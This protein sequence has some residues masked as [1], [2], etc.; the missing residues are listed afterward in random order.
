MSEAGEEEFNLE[1]YFSLKPF[2]AG[3][4]FFMFLTL[5]LLL[6]CW[7]NADETYRKRL[8]ELES[9]TVLVERASPASAP[10]ANNVNDTVPEKNPEPQT[11]PPLEKYENGMI[12]APVPGLH[13]EKS[14]G[15]PPVIREDGLSAFEA[16]R[17]PF[18]TSVVKYAKGVVSLVMT[19]YGL[20][21]KHSSTAIDMLPENVTMLISPYAS[22]KNE[23]RA[24]ARGKGHE[25]WLS[26]PLEPDNPLERDTGSL[27][28]MTNTALNINLLR[29]E[30]VMGSMTGYAGLI[31]TRKNV[32]YKSEIEARKVIE[33]I[34][35]RG[36]AYAD[37]S[38][39]MQSVPQSIS[40]KNDSPYVH[41]DIWLDDS[42]TKNTIEKQIDALE[43]IAAE[44][45]Y[46]VAF[47]RP[48]PVTMEIISRWVMSLG[49]EDIILV[50]LSVQTWK[51]DK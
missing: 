45:G 2:L 22:A 19:G 5:A 12:K 1:N 48:Y 34:Y 32:F 43:K 3:L 14:T 28:L 29:A 37:A 23:W 26:L 47:F 24:K 46:A 17:K 13:E 27:T 50:P 33:S 38:T 6:W 21:E 42:A 44:R 7:I 16:Y 30:R 15:T 9:V 10:V 8:S 35:K 4:G 20:S 25:L 39:F 31:A 49:P 11:Y 40:M 18:N 36:L 51:T 41:A